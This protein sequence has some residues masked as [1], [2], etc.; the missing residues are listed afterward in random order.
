MIEAA[1]IARIGR[2]LAGRGESG[3][4]AIWDVRIDAEGDLA[5]DAALL[6][7]ARHQT[8]MRAYQS[9]YALLP[10]HGAAATPSSSCGGATSP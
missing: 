5:D 2:H 6:A 1:D 4:P 8:L 3:E 7:H 10:T 9:R